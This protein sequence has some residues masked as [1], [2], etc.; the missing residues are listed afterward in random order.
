MQN[1]AGQLDGKHQPMAMDLDFN[2]NFALINQWM[3]CS[4]QTNPLLWTDCPSSEEEVWWFIA[5][6]KQYKQ[7]CD[8]Y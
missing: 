1:A 8:P 6:L 4:T 2:N 7:V 3:D 5:K